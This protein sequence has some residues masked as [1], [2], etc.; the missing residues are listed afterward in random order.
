MLMNVWV[1]VYTNIYVLESV[2][3]VNLVKLNWFI[4]CLNKN[5][6]SSAN[7]NTLFTQIFMFLLNV[8]L[9]NLLKLISVFPVVACEVLLYV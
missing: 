2:Y 7:A 9:V 3:L 5:R 6:L 1:V 8:Y 4:S